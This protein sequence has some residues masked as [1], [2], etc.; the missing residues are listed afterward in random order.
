MWSSLSDLYS[1]TRLGFLHLTLLITLIL[2]HFVN[3]N[4][5][6]QATRTV[7]TNLCWLLCGSSAK[8]SP[9]QTLSK[10]SKDHESYLE[11]FDWGSGSRFRADPRSNI[12]L[13][14]LILPHHHGRRR[15]V[16]FS[17]KN[18]S[19]PQRLAHKTSFTNDYTSFSSAS[20]KMLHS[21]LYSFTTVLIHNSSSTTPHLPLLIHNSLSAIPYL[22]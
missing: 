1:S 16:I 8:T 3:N 22:N 18:V 17:H 10:Q 6:C 11:T 21:Q 20:S 9:N 7:R 15:P 19:S 13:F 14:R 12:V 4:K 5:C 2:F